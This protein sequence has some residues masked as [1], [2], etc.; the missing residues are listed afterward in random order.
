MNK[1]IIFL[2]LILSCFSTKLFADGTDADGFAAPKAPAAGSDAQFDKRLPPV[3][4]GEEVKDGKQTLKVW[5]TTGGVP[6][7]QAPEPWR[8]SNLRGGRLPAEVGVIVERD[9]D[10]NDHRGKHDH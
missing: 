7:S 5:S 8:D 10:R 9:Q 6:V 4:P 2:A 3:L 1:K